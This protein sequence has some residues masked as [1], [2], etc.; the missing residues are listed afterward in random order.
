VQLPAKTRIERYTIVGLLGVGGTAEVYL[1]SHENL[2]ALYALKVLRTPHPG[3]RRRLLQEGRVQSRLRHPNVVRVLDVVDVEGAPG[4]VMEYIAGPSLAAF[5]AAMRP[6][7][8][9]IDALARGLMAGVAAAHERGMIHRDLKPANVLLAPEGDGCSLVPRVTDFGMAKVFQL[10]PTASFEGPLTRT[11]AVLGTPAYMAPEQAVDAS[12]VDARADVWALGCILYELVTGRRALDPGT[13]FAALRSGRVA[14]LPP[15]QLVPELPGR[16]E[17]AIL[18]A[19]QA[20]PEDRPPDAGALL[21]L[22]GAPEAGEGAWD[23]GTVEQSRR[24][25]P[26]ADTEPR[27]RAGGGVEETFHTSTWALESAP[28]IPTNLPPEVDEFVGRREEL[29]RL[30][31]ALVAPAEDPRPGRQGAGPQSALV[32]LR[33]P[34]GAGK[35]RIARRFGRDSLAAWPGG[36]YFCELADA[37]GL[38]EL[39]FAVGRGLDVVLGEGEPLDQL[40]RAIAARGR[41][42]VILDNF[43]QLTSVAADAPGRW[44]ELAPEARFLVTSRHPLRL[45]AEREVSLGPLPLPG[46]EVPFGELQLNPAVALFVTR[47]RVAR[48]SFSLNLRNAVAVRELVTLLEGLPL[49]IEL[50]AARARVMKPAQMLERMH[51]RFELLG[52]GPRS[53]LRAALDSS[54]ELLEDWERAA[55]AQL[56]VFEGGFTLEAAEAVLDLSGWPLAPWLVDVIQSLVD[57]SLVHLDEAGGGG[58]EALRFGLYAAIR[59]YAAEKLGG[60]AEAAARHGA[61]FATFGRPEALEAL[62]G[63]EGPE[64][65]RERSRDLENLAAAARRGPP[66]VRV[67]AGLAALEVM[68]RRGPLPGAAALARALLAGE[69][70]AEDRARLQLALARALNA[71]GEQDEALEILAEAVASGALRGR[72]LSLQAGVR[73]AAGRLDE[74]RADF[75]RAAALLEDAPHAL[76]GALS[77]LG[78]IHHVQGRMEAAEGCLERSL[79]LARGLGDRRAQARALSDL[80][81]LRVTGSR[82]EDAEVAYTEA[83]ELFRQAGDR[84]SEV[85]ALARLGFLCLYRADAE[86][87][88][89]WLR[90]SLAVEEEVG[91]RS[92]RGMALCNLGNAYLSEG[93]FP[94]ATEHY[95]QAVAASVATGARVSELV[96]RQN[97]G[98]CLR[99][100]GR[101]AEAEVELRAVIAGAGGDLWVQASALTDL[102][103]VLRLLGRLDEAAAALSQAKAHFEGMED[104]RRAAGAICGLGLVCAARGDLEGAIDAFERAGRRNPL[105][106]DSDVTRRGRLALLY[107]RAG[108]LEE[109]EEMIA[110]VERGLPLD[111]VQ[112]TRVEL[113]CQRGEIALMRGDWRRGWRCAEEAQLLCEQ[114]GVGPASE[115]SRAVAALRAALAAAEPT[116][117][118]T[119]AP[120]P[121]P[122]P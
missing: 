37:A 87:A 17:A 26:T 12:D 98:N 13:A 108:R 111:L 34:A 101:P 89:R 42:L 103:G 104:R 8:A 57:Q 29:G 88:R 43:E 7:A 21:A 113:L 23:R 15:R 121:D 28:S 24:L 9:Q 6:T 19:L 4:L 35:T 14:L 50:A 73:R 62:D 65:L 78:A 59:V 11:G 72:A 100:L 49:A 60:D 93:R 99:Y 74:A 117:V 76:A 16:W 79:A 39:L 25:A 68:L 105:P 30:W 85:R 94:E 86:G 36:V 107:A 80:A 63:P 97:L 119:P 66:E 32:T 116:E 22:W 71:A 83:L 5:L 120:I 44:L 3:I 82:F 77:Q 96:A 55:L 20:D 69:P 102:G 115:F 1:V 41:C 48:R 10:D 95:R 84:H 40:G 91:S 110:A 54:W 75:E 53:P 58:E 2:G 106:P 122:A 70:A 109:A 31:E 56:S 64:R 112:M 38:E 51:R 81:T 52:G 61:W 45:P 47:A 92:N 67:G 18:A 118:T 33:G 27:A 90:A 114:M 46:E